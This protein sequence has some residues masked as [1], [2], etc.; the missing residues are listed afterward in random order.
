MATL[1]SADETRELEWST[2]KRKMAAVLP[3][4]EE[5]TSGPSPYFN[6]DDEKE[7]LAACSSRRRRRGR[8]QRC[9]RC[10][11]CCAAPIYCCSSTMTPPPPSPAR[12][13]HRIRQGRR[14]RH[15][16]ERTGRLF[17]R[18]RRP[19]HRINPRRLRPPAAR[20]LFHLY[21]GECFSEQALVEN[22]RRAPSLVAAEDV[23]L[24]RVGRTDF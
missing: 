8:T 16:D 13:A 15:R 11:I 20:P 18:R 22:S 14:D 4:F 24:L 12:C 1:R 2:L 6:L 23:T 3:P 7:M 9:A 21:P 17:T 10:S 19:V 5:R